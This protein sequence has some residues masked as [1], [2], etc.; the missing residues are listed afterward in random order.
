MDALS[1][2]HFTSLP[3]LGFLLSFS[4]ENGWDGQTCLTA[5]KVVVRVEW[6]GDK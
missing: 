4:L 2:H 5:A 6:S 1:A 3:V